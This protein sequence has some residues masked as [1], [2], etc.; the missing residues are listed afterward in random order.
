MD[1]NEDLKNLNKLERQKLL[2]ELRE[3]AKQINIEREDPGNIDLREY[4]FFPKLKIKPAKKRDAYDKL[5][6]GIG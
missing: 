2:E 4:G 1:S 5:F 3:Y 6:P